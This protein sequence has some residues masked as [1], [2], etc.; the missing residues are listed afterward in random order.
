MVPFSSKVRPVDHNTIDLS[1][2]TY[3]CS[4]FHHIDAIAHFDRE[5]IPERVVCVETSLK[6]IS[7]LFLSPFG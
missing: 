2:V 4:D 3:I 7:R 1:L 5:R 6:L